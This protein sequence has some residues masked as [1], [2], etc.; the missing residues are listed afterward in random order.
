MQVSND[1]LDEG[2]DW[3]V[4]LDSEAGRRWNRSVGSVLIARGPGAREQQDGI[5]A[6]F[7]DPRMYAQW[8]VAPFTS[9]SSET[10]FNAYDK[11]ATLVR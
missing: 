2:I 7:R 11:T 9:L 4:S 8:S 3:S 5:G 1:A 10:P 6:A